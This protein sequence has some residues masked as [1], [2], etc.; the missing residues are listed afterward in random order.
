[1]RIAV[2]HH[3]IAL[4]NDY[5]FYLSDLL[6]EYAAWLGYE[7]E[8]VDDFIFKNKKELPENALIGIDVKAA[9]SFGLRWWYSA[10][11]P[12]ILAKAG[13]EAVINLNGILSTAVKLPQVLTIP[14]AGFLQAGA[15][16]EAPWQ[17]LALKNINHYAN[18]AA[19]VITYAKHSAGVFEKI[20]GRTTG[21][22][23]IVPYTAV[24]EYRVW[25]WHEKVM[26]KSNF[27]DNKEFFVSILDDNKPDLWFTVLKAFSKF[28]KWQQS[29]MQLLLIPKNEHAEILVLDKLTTYKY[30]DDVQVLDGLT[31]QEK[32]SL[33]ACA[34]GVIHLPANDADVQPLAEALK[35][36]TPIV[37]V[38]GSTVKEYI[39]ENAITVTGF[40]HEAIGDA[41]ISLYKSED[42]RNL[43]VEH[44]K[45]LAASFNRDDIAK[46]LWE[47]IESLVKP[48]PKAQ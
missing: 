20:T 27:A 24:K 23:Q 26:V 8:L 25:E 17:K 5:G 31:L 42:Q 1:M 48:Q 21:S 11:L 18:N 39:G 46:T 29:N 36:A 16:P 35:C 47:L 14:D 44:G 3:T 37:T 19:A 43:M 4:E 40:D 32:A 12:G 13:V 2:I 22:T 45:T 41:L 15:K 30:K 28:K 38:D 10:K 33:V 34:Y 7:V 9:G 6:S